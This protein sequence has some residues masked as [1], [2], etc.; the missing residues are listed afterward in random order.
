VDPDQVERRW[1]GTG[2]SRG[3]KNHNQD[4]LC[5]KMSSFQKKGEMMKVMET[6]ILITLVL[7][8]SNVYMK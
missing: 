4:I 6:D 5:E 1:E 3:W 2:R 8:S 7:S